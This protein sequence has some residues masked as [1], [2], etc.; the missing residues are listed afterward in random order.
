MIH[1]DAALNAFQIDTID[2][3]ENFGIQLTISISNDPYKIL[4]FLEC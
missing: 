1:T 2:L 3:K 4:Y